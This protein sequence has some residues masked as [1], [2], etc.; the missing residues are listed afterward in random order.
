MGSDWQQ[1]FDVL[2]IGGGPAGMAAA[3]LAAECGARVGMV[4]DNTNAGGQIWRTAL[5]GAKTPDAATWSERLRSA[6]V[7]A[8]YGKRVFDQPET[9]VLLA[10]GDDGLCEL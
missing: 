10:E 7:T 1:R 9:G 5:N 4:D 8:L 6:K 3:G 2:V